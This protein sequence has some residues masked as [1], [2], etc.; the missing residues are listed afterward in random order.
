MPCTYVDEAPVVEPHGN[1]FFVTLPGAKRPSVWSPH[2]L[3]EFCEVTIRR[4]DAWDAEQAGRVVDMPK[5]KRGH[6]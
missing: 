2:A 6:D 3:R 4:M 5:R 1:V